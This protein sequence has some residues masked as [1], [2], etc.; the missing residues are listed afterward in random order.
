V[1]SQQRKVSNRGPDV[2][3][4]YLIPLILCGLAIADFS[5]DGKIDKFLIGGLMV[6]GLGSL[7]YRIDTMFERYFEGRSSSGENSSQE[8]KDE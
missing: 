2:L 8:N 3:F 5:D 4:A 7:G 1:G 6:F